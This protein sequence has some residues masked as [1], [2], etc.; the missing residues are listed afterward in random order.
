MAVNSGMGDSFFSRCQP[1]AKRRQHRD[2]EDG[3]GGEDAGELEAGEEQEQRPE[4]ERQAADLRI[5]AGPYQCLGESLGVEGLQ[6][7]LAFADADEMHRQ[8]EFGRQ[9]HQNAALGGAVQLGHDQA[10]QR[11][12][13]P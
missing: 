8:A 3:G 9:R 12:R 13:W 7:V 1:S 6:I 5:H 10:G 11:H 2:H 4:I